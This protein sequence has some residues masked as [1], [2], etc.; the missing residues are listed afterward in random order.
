MYI[1]AC[2]GWSIIVGISPRKQV[3]VQE[4]DK[5]QCSKNHQLRTN[6]VQSEQEEDDEEQQEGNDPI[7]PTATLTSYLD[8]SCQKLIGTQPLVLS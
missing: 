8:F 2:R 5:R 6:K 1:N 4:A 7:R 3:G